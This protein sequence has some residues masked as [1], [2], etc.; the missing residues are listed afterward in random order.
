MKTLAA[1][2]LVA[3]TAIGSQASAQ[4]GADLNI[5]PRRVTLGDK[6]R[7]ATV[8]IFNQ[9]DRAATY[10]VDLADR[11]MRPDG[12]IV[13]PDAAKGDAQPVSAAE[14]VQYTP[15]RVTLQ[16][17]ESQLIRVRVT[18]PAKGT[19][20]EY[21]SHLV[22]TALPPEGT[23]LTAQQAAKPDGDQLSM[24]V[25]ALF[26]VSIPVIIREGAVDAR[27]DV[28]NVKRLAASEGAPHGAIQM[29]LVRK[30]ANSVYGDIEVYVGK[31][32]QEKLVTLVR[33]VAV[34]PEIGRR[35][36]TAPLSEDVPANEPMRIV[37]KD[38]DTRHGV[39]L[40]TVAVPAP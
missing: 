2:T 32:P 30:G 29:D 15:R 37:Y 22:V 13:A 27:A 18:S 24:Q 9:G 11:V 3:F 4:V 39:T 10:T 23:G 25:V 7:S 34:Y 21:R 36:V 20:G 17:K 38:D 33:G 40:A 28:D 16:P 5:S 12:Q 19:A 26:S 31:G 14:Y 8:Y 1:L 6:D 35:T